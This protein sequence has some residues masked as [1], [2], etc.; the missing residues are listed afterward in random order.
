MKSRV[1]NLVVQIVG[2]LGIGVG[3]FRLFSGTNIMPDPEAKAADY[4]SELF[5]D[6]IEHR[7]IA[8]ACRGG[9][10][11]LGIFGVLALGIAFGNRQKTSE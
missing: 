8:N 11:G 1:F 7:T 5:K 3:V 4:P 6:V 9:G 2:A 10:L